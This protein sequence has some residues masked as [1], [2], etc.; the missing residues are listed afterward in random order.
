MRNIACI[1]ART[2]STR[3]PQKVLADVNGRK[4]IEHIIDRVKLVNGIDEIYIATSKDPNDRILEEIA[5]AKGIKVY[6]GDENSVIDRMLDIAEIEDAA[7]VIRITSDNIFTDQEILEST[8]IAH[9][10]FNMEYTRAEFLSIGTTAEVIDVQALKRC[11]QMI[12]PNKSEYLFYYIFDPA[13][14]RTLVLIPS[15]KELWQEYTS[16]TVDTELDLYRTKFIYDHIEELN[17]TYREIVQLHKRVTIPYFEIDKTSRIKL[18]DRD[19]M[20]YQSFRKIINQRIEQ[21][22]KVDLVL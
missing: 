16:L 10:K 11:Y 18:P 20:D 15:D 19:N 7:N 5:K 6:F 17:P 12:D 1:I 21:S 9:N 13:N 3:L 22:K 2:N 8:L 14:F 4:L